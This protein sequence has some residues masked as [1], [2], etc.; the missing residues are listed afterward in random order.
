M[1]LPDGPL[2]VIEFIS[3][4]PR[5]HQTKPTGTALHHVLSNMSFTSPVMLLIKNALLVYLFSNKKC[6]GRAGLRL[7]HRW[8]TSDEGLV[9]AELQLSLID[10][11]MES[12]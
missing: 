12:S 9:G 1:Q 3:G 4:S 10:Q 7:E 6:C 8:M 5:Y 11:M 2:R